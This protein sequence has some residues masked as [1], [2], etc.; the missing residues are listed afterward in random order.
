MKTVECMCGRNLRPCNLAR[1]VRAKHE[2]TVVRLEHGALI[3][4]AV[5]PLR[6]SRSHERRYDDVLPRGAGA[7]RFRIYTLTDDGELQVVATVP[8]LGSIG[9]L[10]T[11][12]DPGEWLVNPW[13]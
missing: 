12:D 9:V 2:P 3:R 4:P 7:D 5:D 13:Q 6:Q 11:K 1:H 10:D 8:D